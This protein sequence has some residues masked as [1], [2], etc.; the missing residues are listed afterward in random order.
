MVEG[1]RTLQPQAWI[2]LGNSPDLGRHFILLIYLPSLPGP[3]IP[4][5]ETFILPPK[6]V[7]IMGILAEPETKDADTHTILSFKVND[8]WVNQPVQSVSVMH[9]LVLFQA[10][11]H[12]FQVQRMS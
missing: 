5:P 4:L 9:H 7:R 3:A 6:K 12:S 10:V 11:I 8:T 1:T 2:Q